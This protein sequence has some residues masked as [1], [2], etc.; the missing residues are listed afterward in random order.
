MKDRE[1]RGFIAAVR[2]WPVTHWLAAALI[3]I[4]ALVLVRTAWMSDDAYITLRTIDNFV[5]GFGLTWNVDERVQAYTHPLWMLVLS[6][7]YFVTRDAYFTTLLVSGAISLAVVGLIVTR[8]GASW[9]S[10]LIAVTGLT[11]SKAFTDYSTSGLENPLTH[12]LLVAFFIVL[13][14]DGGGLRRIF[15]L[16][17]IAALLAL[18]R[19]D[20]ILFVAPAYL[21]ALWQTQAEI[22]RQALK[23]IGLILLGFLPLLAWEAF[24]LL[25]YGFLAPNT[26]F[27]KLS[28]GIDQI[29]LVRQGLTYLVRS[30]AIDPLSSLLIVAGLAVAVWSRRPRLLFWAAGIVLYTGYVVWIGGDFMSG[31]F[32]AAPVLGAMLAVASVKCPAL[33]KCRALGQYPAPGRCRALT[34]RQLPTLIAIVVIIVIGLAGPYAPIPGTRFMGCDAAGIG[35]SGVS[36]ERSCFYEG[37][38]LLN[39]KQPPYPNQGLVALGLEARENPAPLHIFGVAG[40]FGYYAGPQKHLVDLNALADPLLARLP[41][42]KDKPWRIGHFERLIPAGY[43]ETL[44]SGE[45]KLC[46]RGLAR[47]YDRL[48]V[49]TR[50]PLFTRDRLRTIWAMNTGQY[51]ELLAQ[52]RMPG[53][54]RLPDS[55]M[56]C[57]AAAIVDVDFAGGPHLRGYTIS[58]QTVAPGGQ[59]LLTLYW[60]DNASEGVKLATFVHVRPGPGQAANPENPGG[61]WAQD[62]HFSPGGRENVEFWRDQVYVDQVLLQLPEEIPPGEYRLEVGWFNPETGEQLEPRPETVQAPLSILW[63]SI[64]LPS[65]QVE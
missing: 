61:H 19:P 43:L 1:T 44:A 17:L 34:S 50:G 46:N 52:Y 2:A 5:H 10:S 53:E 16:S 42:P 47:Y 22:R 23:T 40:I 45:N 55:E 29:A 12:L 8:V 3:A 18:N 62:E 49:I 63:R 15:F 35:P 36:D 57:N 51:D 21:F 48:Q 24:S 30:T 64:L 58:E 31:R 38:G 9:Q 11:L 41:L 32:L 65:L 7:F 14:Q 13:M 54:D 56:L 39:Q 33:S 4:F 60:Q 28:H 37:T 59:V 25:Y 27:A 20:I 6:A 26:Y